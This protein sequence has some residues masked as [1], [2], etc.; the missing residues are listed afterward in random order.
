MGKAKRL[1]TKRR[2]QGT[3]MKNFKTIRCMVCG[4]L[5]SHPEPDTCY[6]C[7]GIGPDMSKKLKLVADRV[8][9]FTL[10]RYDPQEHGT[11]NAFA[12]KWTLADL[13]D[14]DMVLNLDLL[15]GLF[16]TIGNRLNRFYSPDELAKQLN[17]L[18]MTQNL[19]TQNTN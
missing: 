14:V 19:Q 2:T 18:Q 16:F 10:M 5:F 17:E 15:T 3:Q 1:K 9:G 12:V 11:D 7:Q 6:G 4:K 13:S 8:W